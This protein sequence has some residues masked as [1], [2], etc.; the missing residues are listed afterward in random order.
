MGQTW[1]LRADDMR[2]CVALTTQ[3]HHYNLLAHHESR[4]KC[5][6]VCVHL[7]QQYSHLPILGS[8]ENDSGGSAVHGSLKNLGGDYCTETPGTQHSH[9]PHRYLQGCWWTPAGYHLQTPRIIPRQ[10]MKP[11]SALPDTMCKV[12]DGLYHCIWCDSWW[13]QR[14][15]G[16]QVY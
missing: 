10:L 7:R 12:E 15:P 6:C 5:M 3:R 13:R 2:T 9:A 8:T 1:W 16:M 14:L 4:A 11:G